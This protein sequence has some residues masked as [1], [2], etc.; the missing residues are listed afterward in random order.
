MFKSLLGLYIALSLQPMLP[1]ADNIPANSIPIIES[2]A[3]SISDLDFSNLLQV[4]PVPVKKDE[5]ISPII[6][7]P[8][9]VAMDNQT[10]AILYER[11]GN[12]Q[13]QIASITKLMTAVIILEENELSTTVTISK[14]ASSTDGSEMF[15]HNKEK[16]TVENLLYGLLVQSAND[17]AEA[18]A[19]FNAGSVDKFVEK[20]NTKARELGLIN[21]HFQNPVGFDS[22]DNYSSAIDVAR[23]ARYAYQKDFV[24]KVGVIKETKVQST[25]QAYTHELKSTNELLDSYL[26]IKGLKTGTTDKAGPCN[27][28][29]AENDKGNDIIT[30]VLGSPNRFQESKALIDWVFRAYIW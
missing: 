6:E 5:F 13:R 29:I 23:L 3:I 4:S 11:N 25:D 8:S 19:E 24:K 10:G 30:V 17:A 9:A 2:S 21:T 7:A 27:V 16:I 20:M 1:V 14:E 22:K 12:T 18:L 28:A 26:K 15:L